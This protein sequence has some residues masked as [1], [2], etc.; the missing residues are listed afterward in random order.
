MLKGRWLLLISAF[1]ILSG[2]Q[3]WTVRDID[4]LPPTASLPSQSE[5]GWVEARYFDDVPGSRVD[6]LVGI[7]RY[8]DNPDETLQL[9]RLE[10]ALNRANRYG[11]LVRG[12]IEAPSTGRYRFFVSGDD[13]TQFLL[14]QSTSP[15]EAQLVASVPSNSPRN[16]FSRF[17]SQASP[18]FDL[19]VGQRYYF[20]IRH[21]DGYGGDH[22][23]VAWEGPGFGQTIV[24]GQFLYSFA[25]G[26][27]LYPTDELS[28]QGYALG[29]RIGFFDGTQGLPFNAQYPPLDEDQDGLYDNWEVYHSLD[30]ANPG[31]AMSDQDGDF[32]TAYDEFWLG[33]H[34]AGPDSDG[35]GIPDGVEFAYGLNPLN[36]ADAHEDMDG[37]GFSNL[38]EYLAGKDLSDPADYPSA[39]IDYTPGLTGQYFTG[40]DFDQFVFARTDSGLNMD[41]GGGAPAEG[42]PR[43]RF[44]VRWLTQFNPPHSEGVRE[45]EFRV[46][47]DDGARIFVGNSMIMDVWTGGSSSTVYTTTHAFEAG[48]LH[49]LTIEYREGYGS[50]RVNIDVVDLESGRVLNPASIFLTQPLDAEVSLDVD[51]DGIPDAWEL[52]FGLN[53]H[54]PEGR[55][56][57]NPQGVTALQA[58]Q[59][60]QNPWTLE[61]VGTWDGQLVG[62]APVPPPPLQS[63]PPVGEYAPDQTVTLSWVAPATRVDGSSLSLS[64]IEEYEINY[65][66][67]ENN[68]NLIQAVPGG[69][70]NYD[71]E[72][73]ESGTWY[74]QVR[75]VDN[76]GLRSAPSETVSYD[77]N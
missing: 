19:E 68:L 53:P 34:P 8:P 62:S 20:E 46:Q 40:A 47:R 6:D 30:P 4:T 48:T 3:S 74:F 24:D 26:S 54:A 21:K 59:Q 22:F 71:F 73:L 45:Y 44:T 25:Q 61:T 38:E 66:Q 51:E 70:M 5:Q 32:L 27:A 16:D 13:E 37:D 33:T 36:P 35:D 58:Y 63:E 49:P 15:T 18:Y 1:L 57:Y 67:S 69:T 12:Y 64:E 43:D 72:A 55:A 75:A 60:G 29:Y 17:S 11:T 77:V 42:M 76:E 41:W 23:S 9:T 2:C 28:T 56:A 31:D 14:S 39:R 10:G 7:A 52:R 50:A 65:G